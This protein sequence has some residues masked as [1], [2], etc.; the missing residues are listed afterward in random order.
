MD[1]LHRYA[2]NENGDTIFI[3]DVTI[4]IRHNKYYCKNC[5]GE[6][7]PVLGEVRE[8]H[9]RHK[10]ITPSCSYESYIHK[11]G[12][13]IL[14]NRF[15]EQES[16]LIS[17]FIEYS[18]S[19]ENICH[20]KEKLSGLKCNK[21]ER[22]TIDLKQL[23]DS[24]KDEKMYK[25]YKGDLMLWNSEH[26]EREPIFI[27]IAYTHDCTKEKISSGI[28]IIELK[29]TDDQNFDMPFYEQEVMFMDFTASNPYVYNDAPPVRFYNFPRQ[30]VFSISLSRFVVLR[31][32]E[33]TIEGIDV[34]N[35]TTCQDFEYEHI[36][37]VEYELVTSEE[38]MK[39]EQRNNIY[40]Y[41]MAMAIKKG[42]SVKH[43]VFCKR[44]YQGYGG[45]L[46]NCTQT[47]KNPKTNDLINRPVQIWNVSLKPQQID[48]AALSS[49]CNLFLPNLTSVNKML[50]LFKNVPFW[51][52][53]NKNK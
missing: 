46:V 24:C 44:F 49:K 3:K 6:M 28:Q 1:E 33:G 51:D 34:P 29:I 45:C 14:M 40:A 5:G 8:K 27:E 11:I 42:Y 10:V 50:E 37:I 17:Y 23:Y 48:R 9:F 7:I 2:I 47:I 16:F 39:Q 36:P 32:K 38:I 30:D 41:G 20:F 52:W 21:R 18:C 43:C 31:T 53:E 22:R 13:E 15:Y 4:E 12:K 35:K 19:K 25:G 26:P